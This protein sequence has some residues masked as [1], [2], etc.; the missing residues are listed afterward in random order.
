MPWIKQTPKPCFHIGKPTLPG[1]VH[2]GN[3][4][5]KGD[6]WQCPECLVKF[7]VLINPAYGDFRESWP[8]SFYFREMK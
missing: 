6:I 8:A 5:M 4:H 2:D 1:T 3:K 7:E